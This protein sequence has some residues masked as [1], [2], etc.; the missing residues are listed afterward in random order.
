MGSLPPFVILWTSSEASSIIV[1]S[2]LKE[3]SNTLSNPILLRAA[4]I[5]SAASIPG[6]IPNS[7]AMV[8]EMLG[9]CC[10]TT[11]FVGSFRASM[12]FWMLDFSVSAPVGQTLMHWPQL[13]QLDT[14]S[15]SS[16]AVPM[17]ALLPLP[18]KSMQATPC[19]SSQT[20]THLPQRMHLS[21]SRT[22]AGLDWS[23]FQSFLE[24]EYLR[25]LTPSSSA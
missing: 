4:V 24:P 16:K 20:R 23:I 13:M 1:R 6:F 11:V 9:A 15:P 17:C 10:T 12:T 19:I 14:L 21:G 22:M 25:C 18:M 3:V 5:T 7:S 8:T 2:A